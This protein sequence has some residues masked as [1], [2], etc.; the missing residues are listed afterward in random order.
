MVHTLKTWPV[1]FKAVE[2]GIKPFD[3]RKAD[4]LYASGDTLV[5]QEYEPEGISYTGKEITFFIS[6]ILRDTDFP[7]AIK[8]GYCILGLKKEEKFV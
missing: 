4:R 7:A 8:K 6:Y 5:L 1:F 3:L 2:D